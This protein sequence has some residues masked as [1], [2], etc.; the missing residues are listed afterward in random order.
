MERA[1]KGDGG[2]GSK[3]LAMFR[4]RGIMVV[5]IGEAMS[6]YGRGNS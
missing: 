6:N 4:V 3:E 5:G 2:V 1:K